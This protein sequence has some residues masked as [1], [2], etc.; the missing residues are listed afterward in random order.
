MLILT[1]SLLAL[2]LLFLPDV[3]TKFQGAEITFDESEEKF[4]TI[5]KSLID[6]FFSLTLFLSIPA[7]ALFNKWLFKK[8]SYNYAEH[9][10]IA[11]FIASAVN[12]F[13]AFTYFALPLPPLP[14]KII[15]VSFTL[16]MLIYSARAYV[17]IFDQKIV[18][19]VLKYMLSTFL[20][21]IFYVLE[22]L[23][24]GAFYY[25]IYYG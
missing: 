9:V 22:F 10:V 13:S 23:V 12:I 5:F 16:I 3:P 1:T 25:Y 19:G 21:S 20:T 7:A 14:Q 17:K 8:Q 6:R 11:T 4:A 18:V 15:G 2:I 24:L